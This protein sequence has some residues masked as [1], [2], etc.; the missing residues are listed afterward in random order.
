MSGRAA[1]A[2]SSI[3]A[4]AAVLAALTVHPTLVHAEDPDGPAR[5]RLEVEIEP[6]RVHVGEQATYRLR[7]L[8]RLD[9]SDLAWERPL[10]F[11]TARAEWL[12][13]RA[14][15]RTVER[16]GETYR[17]YSER[18]AVFPVQ[19]GTLELPRAAVRCSTPDGEE[20][21][22]T[23]AASLRVV[24]PPE[25]GRPPGFSGVVGRVQLSVSVDPEAITVGESVRL[26]VMAR[27]TGNLWTVRPRLVPEFD[28]DTVEV[29]AHPP[30][31]A[32]DAGRSLVVRRYFAYDIVPHRPGTL[33]LPRV[34]LDYFDPETGRYERAA[35]GGSRVSVAPARAREPAP[36]TAHE[37]P[38]PTPQRTS[39]RTLWLAATGVLLATGAV[40]A[41]TWRRRRGRGEPGPDVDALLAATREAETDAERAHCACAAL[42]AAL[43]ERLPRARALSAEE[44]LAAARGDPALQAAIRLLARIEQ[45]RFGGSPAEDWS[46][47]DLSARIA[48]LRGR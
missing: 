6:E 2:R 9:V 37:P 17:V 35:A 27:G 19:A 15:D 8:R 41:R 25:A 30:E 1:G 45:A 13:G 48:A 29:F 16:A 11:P 40:A 36:A 32:R 10:A 18:R 31:S 24:E 7:I 26:S 39:G 14:L 34:E 3:A 44:L 46:S 38:P 47:D 23:P 21:V 43:A 5:C 20:I 12:P 28:G 4:H 33:R 42:R 22:A